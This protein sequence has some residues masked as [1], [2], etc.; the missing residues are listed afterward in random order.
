VDP[1]ET[2]SSGVDD[3]GV[4]VGIS[5]GEVSPE[6]CVKTWLSTLVNDELNESVSALKTFLQTEN[7]R[8]SS[9]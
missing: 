5:R 4:K 9:S 3:T 1:L 8:A 7:A 6:S 2:F